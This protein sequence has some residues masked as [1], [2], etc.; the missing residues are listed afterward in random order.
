ML[1]LSLVAAGALVG[2]GGGEAMTRRQ[3]I[4]VG[5]LGAGAT[6]LNARAPAA[7]DADALGARSAAASAASAAS[8][9]GKLALPS[10]GLG[11]WAWGDS[12]FWG[13]DQK[14]DGELQE[15]KPSLEIYLRNIP[16][17]T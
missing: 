1:A 8:A 2:G 11:A 7:S 3:A 16:T 6:L 10:I 9:G 14:K 17:C 12:L 13:Y 5:G 15:T 4:E